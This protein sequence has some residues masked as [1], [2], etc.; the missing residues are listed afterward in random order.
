[1]ASPL[2]R[3]ALRHPLLPLNDPTQLPVRNRNATRR[4]RI[5]SNEQSLTRHHNSGQPP[6]RF[7]EEGLD[8]IDRHACSA[9][10]A[11][12]ESHAFGLGKTTGH[13]GDVFL[14]R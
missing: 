7:V 12:G 13:D 4:K 2:V 10:V 11:D 9:H 1:M 14:R 6:D 5:L 3:G 8:R